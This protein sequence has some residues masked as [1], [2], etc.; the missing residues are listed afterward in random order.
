MVT[1]EVV[2]DGDGIA[3]VWCFVEA[4]DKSCQQCGK[5]MADAEESWSAGGHTFCRECFKCEVCAAPLMARDFV[6]VG[7]SLYC[8]QH[9]DVCGQCGKPFSTGKVVTALGKRFHLG[10]FTCATCARPFSNDESILVADGK[11]Y[12]AAH[13]PESD[14][15]EEGESYS[16][17][18]STA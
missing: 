3:S 1:V 14:S 17:S 11:P 5:G 12:C 18:S 8:P 10:C 15:D 2:G 16:Y 9:S 4:A 6:S 7:P 13:A